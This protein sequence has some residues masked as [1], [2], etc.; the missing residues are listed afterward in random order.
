ME[1]SPSIGTSKLL[2]VGWA[3]SLPA[4]GR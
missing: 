1:R 2:R 3:S 4:R